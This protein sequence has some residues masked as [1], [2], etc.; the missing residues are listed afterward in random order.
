MT[1]GEGAKAT[2]KAVWFSET[3]GP[4]N[5]IFGDQPRPEPGPEQALIRVLACGVNRLDIYARTGRTPVKLPHISGSEA[6]G[7]VVG[8]GPGVAREPT[9]VGS[10]VAIA[11]YLFC[12]QCEYCR[13]GEETRCVRGDIL[14]LAS[15]GA[16]AEYAVVPVSSLVP[17]PD[18][19]D[20]ISAAAVGL[21][22]ITAWRLLIE[23]A[24]LRAG[25]TALVQAG[26]S[27]VGSAGVQIAKLAGARVIAT[28]GSSEKMDL[29]RKLGADEVINYREQDFAQEVRRL[30]NKRGVSVVMEHIGADTWEKSIACLARGGR[31]AICGATT[32]NEGQTPI[33]TLFAKE[34]SLLGSY[35]G[36]RAD[37][38]T[39]LTLIAAGKLKP[40]IHRTLPLEN[41]A[42]AQRMLESRSTFGKIVIDTTK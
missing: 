35:G 21:A 37:L 13:L 30:T 4:E 20:A 1:A 24:K 26:G 32:G 19:V 6:A 42:D 22:M 25:E 5:L 15:P 17:I 33:W 9:G 8:Y 3:G 40:V 12:G 23:R 14:G 28:V 27:G 31:L 2:M 38:A 34:L 29:A 16:F 18:G 10:R 36:T 39:V 41:V 7:E 11:P